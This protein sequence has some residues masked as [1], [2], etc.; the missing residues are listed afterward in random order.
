ML[1]MDRQSSFD[2]LESSASSKLAT[3]VVKYRSQKIRQLH[4]CPA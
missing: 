1:D 3:Q 2:R 4:I